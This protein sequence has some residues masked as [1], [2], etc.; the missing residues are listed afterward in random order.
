MREEGAKAQSAAAV[1]GQRVPAGDVLATIV[2]PSLE[3][4]ARCGRAWVTGPGCMGGSRRMEEMVR[5]GWCDLGVAARRVPAGPERAGG[6][7]APV[8]AAVGPEVGPNRVENI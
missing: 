3:V 7:R 6:Q 8:G 1:V 5:G 4:W 2:T